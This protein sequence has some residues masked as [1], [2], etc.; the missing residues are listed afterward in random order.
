MSGFAWTMLSLGGALF[1]APLEPFA[2]RFALTGLGLGLV[3]SGLIFT[4]LTCI[5]LKWTACRTGTSS[6]RPKTAQCH[7]TPAHQP[8]EL[9]TRDNSSP[10][11]SKRVHCRDGICLQKLGGAEYRTGSHEQECNPGTSF[12]HKHHEALWGGLCSM[13]AEHVLR[14][15]IIRRPECLSHPK[16]AQATCVMYKIII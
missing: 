8:L 5:Y 16:H 14:T 3:A 10:G 4:M 15:G 6:S 7:C 13:P 1:A 11:G 12:T 9:M 2:V